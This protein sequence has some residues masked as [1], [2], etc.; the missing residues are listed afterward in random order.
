MRVKLHHLSWTVTVL[1]GIQMVLAGL[2]VG[3]NAG[4]VCP[5]WPLC[6]HPLQDNMSLVFELS[7]RIAAVVLGVL[8][9][10]LFLWILKAYRGNKQMVQTVSF[11]IISLLVQII[12]AGMIVLFVL[13]G[14]AT[15]VDVVNSVIML[16]LFVHLSNLATKQS[17]LVN[18][19]L[20]Q[21]SSTDSVM[22]RR[23]W[24]L[25]WA[26]LLT[27]ALGA[28][29][30]H[31][32]ASQELFGED[33]YLLSHGQHVP[34]SQGV[35]ESLLIIHVGSTLLL[36]LSCI[37]FIMS[38]LLNQFLVKT[39]LM[40]TVLLGIQ[41]ALGILSLMSKLQLF[42]VTLHWG[43]AALFMGCCAYALSKTYSIHSLRH[44]STHPD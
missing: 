28:V 1:V 31:S 26:G 23:A 6:G 15:T 32:G 29:F 22:K 40:I 21:I 33:S 44:S 24:M 7:H 34:P 11:A 39:S 36:L 12:Y 13:P 17:R 30:R 35:S 27:V 2:I 3:E 18:A 16:S 14:V 5:N 20:P 8:S 37:L 38:S 41:I 19:P 25:Y 42:I 43:V 10:W 4:F 9:L